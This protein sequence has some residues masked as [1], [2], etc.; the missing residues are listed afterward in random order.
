MQGP[1]MFD[2]LH[3]VLISSSNLEGFGKTAFTQV[4]EIS[5]MLAIQS[6]LEKS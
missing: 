3:D 4:M 2:C 6:N 5:L 1:Y